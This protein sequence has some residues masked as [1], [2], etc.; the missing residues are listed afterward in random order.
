MAKTHSSQGKGDDGA[1][2]KFG[3]EIARRVGKQVR[4]DRDYPRLARQ[5]GWEGT[6]Q[7]K[8][9]FG[10]DGKV[11]SFIVGGSSGYE[12]LDDKALEIIRRIEMPRVPDVLRA[13]EFT[14]HVPIVFK[15]KHKS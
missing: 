15:L 9:L 14:V 5:N 6:T 11:K 12:V 2:E 13:Q 8:L 4:E 7:V 3:L 1:R 10:A